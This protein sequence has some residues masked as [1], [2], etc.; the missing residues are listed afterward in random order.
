VVFIYN[1]DYSLEADHM[2]APVLVSG[3][4]LVLYDGDCPF[5][6]KSISIVKSLD[7]FKRLDFMSCRE[8]DKIPLNTANLDA[9]RMIEEMHLLTPDRR[10][11]YP[12]FYAFRW[13]ASRLPLCWFIWP[14]LFLPGVPYLGKKVYR[15][16]AK[17][18]FKIVPCHDGVCTIPPKRS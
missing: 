14:L 2:T 9:Q 5:C 18:R 17:N 10:R 16:I 4:G 11:A 15:W 12:G 6:L 1:G 13:M 8:P 7:W 3:R